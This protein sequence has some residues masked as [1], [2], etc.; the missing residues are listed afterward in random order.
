MFAIAA[1]LLIFEGGTKGWK[2]K[3][4]RK[5]LVSQTQKMKYQMQIVMKIGRYALHEME[6]F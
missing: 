2:Q 6:S 3:E 4:S 5:K 1:F